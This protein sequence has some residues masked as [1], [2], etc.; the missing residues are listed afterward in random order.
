MA[1]HTLDLFTLWRQSQITLI[2]VRKT[3]ST[4]NNISRAHLHPG[5]LAHVRIHAEP[6]PIDVLTI[7]QY[8]GTATQ[9]VL[10]Q[11]KQLWQE[12]DTYLRRLPS[13][14]MLVCSGDLNCHL[15]SVPNLAPVSRSRPHWPSLGTSEAHADSAEFK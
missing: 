13:R 6:R 9:T 1:R 4:G 15:P 12:L 7:Y 10:Q 5:R 11:R 14:N 2:M 8:S 3:L